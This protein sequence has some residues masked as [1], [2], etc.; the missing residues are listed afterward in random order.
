M[1]TRKDSCDILTQ[2]VRTLKHTCASPTQ[3]CTQSS[4]LLPANEKLYVVVCPTGNSE[5]GRSTLIFRSYMCR[6]QTLPDNAALRCLLSGYSTRKQHPHMDTTQCATFVYHRRRDDHKCPERAVAYGM[7]T[8]PT[9]RMHPKAGG[10][11]PHI[12]SC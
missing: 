7:P 8:H 9:Q 1:W 5:V 4:G 3:A 10:L 11:H 12:T 2:A 6:T